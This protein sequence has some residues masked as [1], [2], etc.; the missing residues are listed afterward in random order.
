MKKTYKGSCH[1]GAVRFEADI[2]LA[3]GTVKCNCSMCGKGRNWLA[4]VKADAF[5]LLTGEGGLG[6]YQFGRKTIRHRFCKRCGLRPFSHGQPAG[7]DTFYAVNVACLDETDP[8]ELMAAPVIFV[9]G[10]H[11]DFKN[12]PQETRHL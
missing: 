3:Q 4:A 10:R 2:D 6:E 1:C 9:D 5:R 12:P 11:D 7:G 8:A